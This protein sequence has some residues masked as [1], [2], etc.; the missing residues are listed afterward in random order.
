M[1]LIAFNDDV[2]NSFSKVK[3]DM[4][5][6]KRGINSNLHSVEEIAKR[7]D[8]S[9]HK[10]EFYTFVKRLGS[11]L[12]QIE[13]SLTEISG[14]SDEIE[15]L[16]ANLGNLEKK[17]DRQ[18]DITNEVKEVRKLR[19]KIASVEGKIVGIKRFNEEINSLNEQLQLARKDFVTE[20]ELGKQADKLADVKKQFNKAEREFAYKAD[21]D[22]ALAAVREIRAEI[23]NFKEKQSKKTSDSLRKI[24][25]TV[26]SIKE[27]T[28]TKESFNEKLSETRK[29]LNNIQELV[30][31]SVSE[32]N[33]GDYVTKK[34]LQKKFTSF[35][36]LT[37]DGERL[38]SSVANLSKEIKKIKSNGASYDDVD[39]IS[40]SVRNVSKSID[41]LKDR[42]SQV[43]DTTKKHFDDG[44]K[45]LQNKHE[46]EISSLKEK[47]DRDIG[48][49]KSAQ[50]DRPSPSVSGKGLFSKI[51][52]GVAEFFKEEEE[53]PKV[54]EIKTDVK[55]EAPRSQKPKDEKKK[56]KGLG[57]ILGVLI[58]IVIIAIGAGIFYLI[59]SGDEQA[60]DTTVEIVKDE[61]IEVVE[62]PEAIPEIVEEAMV[63]F[64]E[65]EPEIVEALNT[66]KSCIAAY[67]CNERAPE[68]YWFDCK[69]DEKSSLCR[70]FVTDAEGC[71]IEEVEDEPVVIPDMEDETE[72][73]EGSGLTLL[74][75][76]LL[77]V[78]VLALIAYTKSIYSKKTVKPK[79]ESKK[80][81]QNGGVDLEEF[82]EKKEN[83]KKSK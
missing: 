31:N 2:K 66:T 47:L 19:G 10:E 26:A 45:S 61:L 18:D 65:T 39:R 24:E 11:R 76:F 48:K 13:S 37:S 78:V 70:C 15:D 75:V 8:S 14:L 72:D 30:D 38:S 1:V 27:E 40:E 53:K 16:E 36:Y 79:V 52:K 46:R 34:D 43:V 57:F 56:G 82:F 7:L 20:T 50:R 12:D 22:T 29:N 73:E 67:E 41:S 23:E 4:L 68:E 42:V 51:G 80:P 3:E 44:F 21:T 33:L 54:E 5:D 74:Y 64:N 49:I 55:K 69:F 71:G 59:P 83:D 81:K 60:T 9:T 28:V 58:V 77:A 62:E 25:N 6:L 63:D 32:V 35:D 17:Q